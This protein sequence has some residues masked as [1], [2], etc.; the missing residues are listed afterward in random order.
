[1]DV[2]GNFVGEEFNDLTSFDDRQTSRT[3]TGV[4]GRTRETWSWWDVSGPSPPPVE[5]GRHG[6]DENES[7]TRGWAGGLGRTD[8]G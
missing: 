8:T 2:I 6:R 3:G 7:P 5:R 4:F 1:M